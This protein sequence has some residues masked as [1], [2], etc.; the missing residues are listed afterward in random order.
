MRMRGIDKAGGEWSLVTMTWNIQ[1][2]HVLR[3]A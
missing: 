1:R 3:A 2:L